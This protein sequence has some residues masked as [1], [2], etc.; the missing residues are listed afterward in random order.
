MSSFQTSKENYSVSRIVKQADDDIQNTL[1]QGEVLVKIDRFAFTA[2]NITY[3]VLGDMI[4]YWEFFPVAPQDKSQWGVIPVW[5]FADVVQS[6]SVDLP[7]GDRLF[8]YFP[9]AATLVM[10]PNL[11]TTS[12]FV[13]SSAHRSTLPP[14][15]NLYQ[16]VLANPRYDRASD[17]EHMTFYPLFL[18]SYCLCDKLLT[19]DWYDAEQI[20]IVSA[21]SKTSVG[22][23]YALEAQKSAP[24][25][26]GLTSAGNLDTVESLGVYD[27]SCAYEDVSKLDSTK[28]TMIVDM[29]GNAVLLAQLQTHFADN[30]RFTLNV[31]LTHWGEVSKTGN[32]NTQRSEMFFAPSQIQSLV[33]ALGRAEFERKTNEFIT[34]T[35]AK[36][37]QWMRFDEREG[38]EG[39]SDVYGDVCN[40]EVD[41]NVGITIVMP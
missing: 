2:N 33:K 14:G 35:A 15:Y 16:R 6:E 24:T 18:T 21:S 20:I 34:Q 19:N 11:V 12:G 23:A 4:R 8:G 3:A 28:R 22:L 1:K 5:G 7:V 41:A 36:T 9:P 30:L 37:R 31:G 40:G 17:N 26:I 27:H 32:A 25:V 13:E 39:L 38:L 29:S 10:T